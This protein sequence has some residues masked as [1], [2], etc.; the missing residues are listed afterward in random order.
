MSESGCHTKFRD[1]WKVTPKHLDRR[2]AA[3]QYNT[4]WINTFLKEDITLF[5]FQVKMCPV[6]SLLLTVDTDL[7][8]VGAQSP[9]CRLW[10]QLRNMV[11][12]WNRDVLA[13][14]LDG[15]RKWGCILHLYTVYGLK[16]LHQC[17]WEDFKKCKEVH[18]NAV[19]HKQVWNDHELWYDYSLVES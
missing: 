9:L 11:G 15:G 7:L 6:I 2:I 16:C 1:V 5:Y 12:F 18:G 8:L 4:H 14:F 3:V 17:C 19:R 13:S 10:L